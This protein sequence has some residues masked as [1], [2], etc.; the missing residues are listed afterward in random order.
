MI[1]SLVAAIA[2]GQAAPPQG[3][4]LLDDLSRR[5][6]LFFWT[7]TDPTSGFTKDRAANLTDRDNYDVCSIASNG[8][9]LI[10]AAVGAERGW[11]NRSNALIRARLI[12]KQTLEKAPHHKGWFYHFFHWKTGTRVWQSEV[13]SIDTAIFLSGAIVAR[14]YFKDPTLSA[15]VDAI[16]ARVDWN[17]MLTNGGTLPNSTTFCHGWRP[18][19]G[20]IPHRWASYCEHMML[21]VLALG[22]NPSYPRTL[23]TSWSRPVVEYRGFRTIAGGP[24]FM[25]QMSHAF[26]DLKN[27]KDTLGWDYWQ[28]SEQMTRANREYCIQNPKGFKDYGPL[29]W[30]LNACDNPDGYGAFGAPG[31]GEDNGTVSPTGV[32]ASIEFTPDIVIP[33]LNSMA[34]KYP[35]AYGR[36]GFS[37][38]LN[39]H[40]NWIGPDVI[41]IDLGMAQAA[42]ENHRDGFVRRMAMSHPFFSSG[43]QRAGFPR[44]PSQAPRDGTRTPIRRQ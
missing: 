1:T 26:L 9:A 18:E 29:F 41:G 15:S 8:Y 39:P 14:Q 40:R 27:R 30:G 13:S 5:A 43:M 28:S 21:Y 24:I 6:A 33:T 22:A 31:W 25:H 17:W 19:T 23:W 10:S 37:N 36:F 7:Q 3:Q 32:A 2:L 42:I 35:G 38:A 16:L 12:A 20:W 4:A 44:V 34:T 11:H